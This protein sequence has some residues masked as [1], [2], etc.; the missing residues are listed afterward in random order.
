MSTTTTPA[1]VG[2]RERKKLEQRQRIIDAAHPMF[3]ALGFEQ[4]TMATV[5]AAT[6]I[7]VK[8]VFNYFP[9]KEDLFFACAADVEHDI[10]GPIARRAPAQSVADAV[11]EHLH[12]L[13][14]QLLRDDFY[15]S[16]AIRGRIVLDSPA[17][18]NRIRARYEEQEQAVAAVL[19][20]ESADGS[21]VPVTVAAAVVVSVIR[22]S[23]DACMRGAAAERLAPEVYA[24]AVALAEHSRPAL[25]AAFGR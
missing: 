17:L 4:T 16:L 14:R 9:T 11:L 19:G 20:R 10:A 3:G 7:S 13:H 22:V 18:R 24:E 5:A 21:G 6:D 12:G 23:L 25:E 15:V 2:L 8:T 1:P